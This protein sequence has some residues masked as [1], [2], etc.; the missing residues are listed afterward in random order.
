MSHLQALVKRDEL[1]A[2]LVLL[3]LGIAAKD[4]RFTARQV[5][6]WTQAYG[7]RGARTPVVSHVSWRTNDRRT[8]ESPLTLELLCTWPWEWG[9]IRTTSTPWTAWPAIVTTMRQQLLSSFPPPLF[10]AGRR[11]CTVKSISLVAIIPNEQQ[12]NELITMSARRL[13][14][15]QVGV[16]WSSSRTAVIVGLLMHCMT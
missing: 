3:L 9:L 4:F 7:A 2:D 6:A 12:A 15:S 16:L 10:S 13:S 8:C 14:S 1:S 11:P 5:V